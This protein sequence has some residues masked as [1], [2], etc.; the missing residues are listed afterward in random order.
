[1]IKTYICDTSSGNDSIH[2]VFIRNIQTLKDFVYYDGFLR[3][4][5]DVHMTRVGEQEYPQYQVE[6]DNEK[7]PCVGISGRWQEACKLK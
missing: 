2:E 7:I 6:L 1:M 3:P 5:I 4:I